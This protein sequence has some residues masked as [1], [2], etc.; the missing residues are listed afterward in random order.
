MLLYPIIGD[1]SFDHLVKVSLKHLQDKKKKIKDKGEK[2]KIYRENMT[3][4]IWGDR[5][6]RTW[7]YASLLIFYIRVMFDII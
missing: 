3:N 7:K 6:E 4:K 5:V 2:R 1:V